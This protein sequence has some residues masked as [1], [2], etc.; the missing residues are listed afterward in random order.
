MKYTK[1]QFEISEKARTEG[2]KN[3][4]SYKRYI[5]KIK[6]VDTFYILPSKMNSN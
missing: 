4:K 6:P 1:E 5:D 3:Y 2:F